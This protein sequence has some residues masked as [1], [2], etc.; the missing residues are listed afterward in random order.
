MSNSENTLLVGSLSFLAASVLAVVMVPVDY[1]YSP[2][3]RLEE[4]A[5]KSMTVNEIGIAVDALETNLAIRKNESKYTYENIR[6]QGLKEFKRAVGVDSDSKL[7][8][9]ITKEDN[10]GDDVMESTNQFIDK[11]NAAQLQAEVKNKDLMPKEETKADRFI[12]AITGVPE[13][14]LKENNIKQVQSELKEKSLI[15][16]ADGFDKVSENALNDDNAN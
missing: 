15:L 1:F 9:H 4:T 6:D 3:E 5:S 7:T 14:V 8:P 13:I 12:N 16:K 10:L 11:L 2:Y